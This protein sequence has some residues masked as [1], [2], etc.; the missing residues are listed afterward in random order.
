MVLAGGS[1][2]SSIAAISSLGI[3][4][5]IAHRQIHATNNNTS[6]QVR[7]GL[8]AASK[9][10]WLDCLVEDV[11]ELINSDES[12]E[13]FVR[14]SDERP[15]DAGEK[16][17]A[18][19]AAERRSLYCTRIELRVDSSG[20]E[21]AQLLSAARGLTR[22]TNND[23]RNALANYLVESARAAFTSERRDIEAA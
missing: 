4:I 8:V 13:E 15:L 6:R 12:L 14:T 16:E 7:A 1:I 20:V 22:R 3:A 17:R 10:K 19:T 18:R 21:H 5:H 2:L 11:A 23:D 9:A